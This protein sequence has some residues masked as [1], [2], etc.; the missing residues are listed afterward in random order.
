MHQV[1][2]GVRAIG[3]EERRPG[4]R[5]VCQA[6]LLLPACFAHIQELSIDKDLDVL[7]LRDGL[8][9]GL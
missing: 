5:P 9:L 7:E 6:R 2:R 4:R 3:Q 1:G 8:L